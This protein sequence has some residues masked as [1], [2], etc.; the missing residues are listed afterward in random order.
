MIYVIVDLG[1]LHL[2][3]HGRLYGPR[4]AWAHVN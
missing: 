2:I 3:F 1:A 4:D